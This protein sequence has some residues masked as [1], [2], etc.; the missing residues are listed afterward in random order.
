MENQL[1]RQRKVLFQR[2]IFQ[3]KG[4]YKKW[5]A[6][7]WISNLFSK[8]HMRLSNWKTLPTT[9]S[10]LKISH[11]AVLDTG[12]WAVMGE[13]EH[14]MR[15]SVSHMNRCCPET[16][17]SLE[18]N[19]R[20]MTTSQIHASSRRCAEFL[21]YTRSSFILCWVSASGFVCRVGVELWTDGANVSTS[22][23]S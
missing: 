7:I 22:P 18:A 9:N 20:R 6:Q 3:S 13:G 5:T 19:S 21:R 17:K 16:I 4:V 2:G 23:K 12:S 14:K 10:V 11:S 1:P 15:P 8:H